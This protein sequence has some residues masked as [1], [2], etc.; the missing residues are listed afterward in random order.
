LAD[1]PRANC[2]SACLIGRNHTKF[3]LAITGYEF[4]EIEG[5]G[6][7]ANHAFNDIL[8]GGFG[9]P[10]DGFKLV[11]RNSGSARQ[12]LLAGPDLTASITIE[13]KVARAG[14]GS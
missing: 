4:P 3:E 2:P 7:D 11:W 10:E 9:T 8:R 5:D 6:Y 13:R 14:S 12:Q 1:R